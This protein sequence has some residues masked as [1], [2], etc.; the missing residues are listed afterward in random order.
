[1]FSHDAR[2]CPNQKCESERVNAVGRPNV[3]C[4]SVYQLMQC[5]KC[6]INFETRKSIPVMGWSP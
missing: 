6:G 1:M 2:R 5:Q 3:V 4:G